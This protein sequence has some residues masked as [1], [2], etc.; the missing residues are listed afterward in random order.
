MRRL[1]SIAVILAVATGTSLAAVGDVHPYHSSAQGL[2]AD[3]YAVETRLGVVVIDPP[4]T[5]ADAHRFRREIDARK[6]PVIGIIITRPRPGEAA[7]LATLTEGLKKVDIFATAKTDAELDGE[8]PPTTSAGKE[9]PV[10]LPNRL[11]KSGDIIRY[12][13]LDLHLDGLDPGGAGDLLVWHPAMRALFTGDLV[14]DGTHPYLGTDRTSPWI[15]RLGEILQKYAAARTIY[16]GRG[17]PG[18][19]VLA[20]RQLGYLDTLQTL[21]RTRLGSDGRLTADGRRDVKKGMVTRF[22]NLALPQ[23]VDGNIDAAARELGERGPAS[24]GPS[25]ATK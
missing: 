19:L 8:R 21:I 3:A 13:G 1:L 7:A 4:V 25:G 11:V 10:R 23:Y 6:K 14:C 24:R 12:D 18:S 2:F 16:P 15:A 17:E 5:V 9:T 20:N 22:P